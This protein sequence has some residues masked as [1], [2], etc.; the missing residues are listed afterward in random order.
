MLNAIDQSSFVQ[1]VL[2]LAEYEYLKAPCLHSVQNVDHNF[3]HWQSESNMDEVESGSWLCFSRKVASQTAIEYSESGYVV[4]N[5][6]VQRARWAHS[7]LELRKSANSG[8]GKVAV[9]F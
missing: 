3:T 2:W 9:P 7:A 6:Y 5:Y 8:G 1:A 4:S